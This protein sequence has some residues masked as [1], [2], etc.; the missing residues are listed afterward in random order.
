[1]PLNA[2]LIPQWGGVVIENYS[3]EPKPQG[4]LELL[5]VDRLKPIM[6]IFL[7]QLRDL[8]GVRIGQ[9]LLSKV[10]YTITIAYL[11]R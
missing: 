3:K 11:L 4:E 6:E 8:L 2:F 7:S 9:S 1:L 10:N 5:T